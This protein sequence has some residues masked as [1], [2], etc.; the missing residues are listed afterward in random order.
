MRAA[1]GHP[2]CVRIL[3]VVL[4]ALG[5]AGATCAAEEPSF[6]VGA[7][8]PTFDAYRQSAQP[9]LPWSSVPSNFLAAPFDAEPNFPPGE[10]RRR[11]RSL[12]EAVPPAEPQIAASRLDT[13]MVQRLSDYR[14]HGQIR[15]LTLWESGANSLSLQA[16]RHGSPSLQWT[17][18]MMQ[19][20]GAPHGVLDHLFAVSVAGAGR[21]VHPVTRPP[22]AKIATSKDGSPK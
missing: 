10:F 17:S 7:T 1:G 15:V 21:A 5:R 8:T 9:T 18:R 4:A 12:N 3:G 22:A 19:H 20:G 14:W 13:P 11:G 6:A 16:G 2:G